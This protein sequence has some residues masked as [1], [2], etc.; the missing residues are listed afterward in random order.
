MSYFLFLARIMQKVIDCAYWTKVGRP[1]TLVCMRYDQYGFLMNKKLI[2]EN[3]ARYGLNE[4]IEKNDFLF[5]K[6]II[7]LA[8]KIRQSLTKQS[9]LLLSLQ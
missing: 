5:L 9:V 8:C 7:E 2:D 6:L 1:H 3:I 4:I